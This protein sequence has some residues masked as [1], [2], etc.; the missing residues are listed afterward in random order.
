MT[1]ACSAPSTAVASPSPFDA[2]APVYDVDFTQ[3]LLGRLA[4][5]RVTRA[6][7]RAFAPGHRVLDLGCGTGEDA[8]HLASRGVHILAMDSSERMVARTREKTA[9][10]GATPFVRA[11]VLSIEKLATLSH[12]EP[13]DGAYS[14]FGA[15]NC[16]PVPELS[17]IAAELARRIRPSGR[18]VLCFMGRWCLW[19]WAYF[20]IRGQPRKAFRRLPKEGA[21]W[22]GLP[23]FYPGLREIRRAFAGHFRF[24]SA[25]GIGT[26][27]PP[28]YLEH[29]AARFP[30]T[31]R[32]LDDLERALESV[33]PMPNF[34]DHVVLEL[35]RP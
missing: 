32:L 30:S 2:L 12:N 28:S 35:I 20:V 5:V 22:R 13:L 21:V 26:L 23:V 27:V 8:I 18:L 4:R 24:R 1:P 3:S 29:W 11:E 9:A 25:A 6:L 7:D 15:L 19:E 17:R 31:T 34:A 14:N 16:I 10:A 33:P